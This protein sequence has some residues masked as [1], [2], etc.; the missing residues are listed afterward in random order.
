MTRFCYRRRKPVSAQLEDLTEQLSFEGLTVNAVRF[1]S[2][3]PDMDCRRQDED[4]PEVL[5]IGD[6]VGVYSEHII[7]GVLHGEKLQDVDG[8]SVG[9]GPLTRKHIGKAIPGTAILQSVQRRESEEDR[10]RRMTR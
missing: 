3:I 9:V 2:N 7:T 5:N 6:R 1:S 4:G 8:R 10:V